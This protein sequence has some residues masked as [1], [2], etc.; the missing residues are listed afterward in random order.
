M[1]ESHNKA[2]RRAQITLDGRIAL[3]AAVAVIAVAAAQPAQAAINQLASRMKTVIAIWKIAVNAAEV[4]DHCGSAIE[5]GALPWTVDCAADPTSLGGVGT[6]DAQVDADL[7]KALTKRPGAYLKLRK[8]GRPFYHG[9]DT[10]CAPA[11]N[12]WDDVDACLY[13]L[14]LA[15]SKQLF[16][17]VFNPTERPVSTAEINC[18]RAIGNRVRGSYRRLVTNRAECFS[19]NGLLGTGELAQRYDC[20]APAV[21][22]SRGIPS[23]HLMRIDD[24][25][26]RTIKELAAA[27]F[28][29]CPDYLAGINFPSPLSDPTGGIFGRSDLSQVL[30]ENVIPMTD[31]VLKRV[32]DGAAHCG[33]GVVQADMGEQCDDGNQVSCDGCDYNCQ[34]PAC[35]NAVGCASDGEQCDDGNTQSGDGCTPACVLEYCGD[36]VLQAGLGELCDDGNNRGGDG[37]TPNCQIEY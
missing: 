14:G 30:L 18:R 24:S 21:P 23:T 28:Y 16:S 32:Y 37:C 36:G 11:S 1:K 31:E 8:Y 2:L 33:D 6:G 15:Q 20:M 12:V 26:G 13:R 29:G 34:L 10:L 27:P 7:E 4:R 19:Q 17:M 3:V 5:S 22:P 9:V 35:G 25:I